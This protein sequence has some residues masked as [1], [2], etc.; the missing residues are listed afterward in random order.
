M[1][2]QQ[3]GEGFEVN[4]LGRLI[5]TPSASQQQYLLSPLIYSQ[6]FQET[7]NLGNLS[8]LNHMH[9]LRLHYRNTHSQMLFCS[10][11]QLQ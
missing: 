5:S 8:I 6:A 1:K 3:D 2:L 11:R 7:H 4:N 9:R 10:T